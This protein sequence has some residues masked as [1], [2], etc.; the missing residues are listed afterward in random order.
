MKK[1]IIVVCIILYISIS[2][3]ETIGE[4]KKKS[5]TDPNYKPVFVSSVSI[6]PAKVTLIDGRT[7]YNAGYGATTGYDGKR[8]NYTLKNT[9]KEPYKGL[10]GDFLID[11]YGNLFIEYAEFKITEE[12]C[13]VIS[14]KI[15]RV[16]K[17]EWE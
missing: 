13:K 11:E 1:L 12:G 9:N 7:F 10:F 14:S 8:L 17:L 6:D 3:C 15:I 16:K 4:L 5:R 2:F